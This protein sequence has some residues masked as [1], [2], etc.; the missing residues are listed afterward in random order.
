MALIFGAITA[1]TR[2]TGKSLFSK[3]FVAVRNPIFRIPAII[4][5][6]IPTFRNPKRIFKKR[7]N[8]AWNSGNRKFRHLCFNIHR[9]LVLQFYYSIWRASFFFELRKEEAY[10]FYLTLK[11]FY[12]ISHFYIINFI[13][14]CDLNWCVA[15]SAVCEHSVR[16][17]EVRKNDNFLQLLFNFVLNRLIISQEVSMIKWGASVIWR[18]KILCDRMKPVLRWEHRST[19]AWWTLLPIYIWFLLVLQARLLRKVWYI[20]S[21]V[22]I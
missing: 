1:H 18:S 6:S 8:S 3:I 13:G 22:T 19:K 14:F 21:K 12:T 20:A 9:H 15:V 11:L 4:C 16:G 10:I 17:L 5:T 7:I 2:P